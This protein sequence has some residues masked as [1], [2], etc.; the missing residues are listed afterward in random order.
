QED[1]V[2]RGS[3]KLILWGKYGGIKTAKTLPRTLRLA[4]RTDGRQG[5]YA[6]GAGRADSRRRALGLRLRQHAVIPVRDSGRNRNI[7][8]ALLRADR[9][10]R[11][12]QRL[13]YSEGCYRRRA[14][15][16]AASLRGDGDGDSGRSA[17]GADLPLR[18]VQEKARIALGRGR[19]DAPY[20][21]RVLVHG[22]PAALGSGGLFRD[23]SRNLDRG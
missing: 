21:S 2:K 12:R 6:R 10:S 3:D 19:V 16:R 11:A 13:L 7:P 1:R 15:S 8:V 18:R 20:H 22:V 23:Q 4:G 5:D 9:G 14:L 17:P